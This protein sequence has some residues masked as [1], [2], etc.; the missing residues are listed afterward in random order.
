[1]ITLTKAQIVLR[2]WGSAWT[3][4]LTWSCYELGPDGRPVWSAATPVSL[5]ARGFAEARLPD[6][7]AAP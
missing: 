6:P 1:M 3:L 2:A 4:A 5:R 7:V